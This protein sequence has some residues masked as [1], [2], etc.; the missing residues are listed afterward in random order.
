MAIKKEEFAALKLMDR[1]IFDAGNEE[2]IAGFV[3]QI[4]RDGGKKVNWDDGC[5]G[6][7]YEDEI[8]SY[9]DWYLPNVHRIISKSVR[10]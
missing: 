1:V 3:S 10:G 5:K 6:V 8:G 2:P 4:Q 7:F 9:L